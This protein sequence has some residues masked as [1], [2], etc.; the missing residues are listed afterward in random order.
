MQLFKPDQ[1]TVSSNTCG[2]MQTRWRRWMRSI[3]WYIAQIC[4]GQR[5]T[6]HQHRRRQYLQQNHAQSDPLTGD[7]SRR[8][9][10]QGLGRRPAG[11]P[12]APTSP[13]STMDKLIATPRRLYN[14]AEV[15]GV[16]ISRSKTRWSSMYPALCLQLEPARQFHRHA[17]PRLHTIP[18]C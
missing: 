4:L 8:D 12:I 13:P 15:K 5:P 17:P 1:H 14:A 7:R 3:A 18:P 11:P 16:K 6:Y 9:V 2:T 10:R